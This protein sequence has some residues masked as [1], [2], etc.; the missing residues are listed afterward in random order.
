VGSGTAKGPI[1]FVNLDP[2]ITLTMG[3]LI[4]ARQDWNGDSSPPT[5][6]ST[7]VKV[8]K[9]PTAA[10]LGEIISRARPLEC[11][12]CLWLE[13]IV[14][15]ATVTVDIP[16]SPAIT[17]NADW[18][19]VHVDVASLSSAATI[20]ARQ[21]A[22]GVI[23]S[24][25][26]LP[27]PLRHVTGPTAWVSPPGVDTPLYLCQRAIT[28]HPLPG[29]EITVEHNDEVNQ[30]CFGATTGTFW[31]RRPLDI[32]DR[33]RVRQQF[34]HCE[35]RSGEGEYNPTEPVPPAPGFPYPVCAG[36]T[37]VEVTG[38]IPGA[39]VQFFRNGEPEPFCFAD[40]GEPPYR[41]N[42]PSL[43]NATRLGVRQTFC[44]F[45]PWSDITYVDIVP[46][47]P[48]DEPLIERP[49]VGCGAAVAVT[50]L[51]A[52]T[53]VRVVSDLWGGP[54]GEAT[55]DGEEFVDVPLHFPLIP[56]DKLQLETIQCGVF[57]ALTEIT[58]VLPGPE[59]LASPELD[60]PLDDCGGRITV[61]ALVPGA[62]LD[63]ERV[64][65][66]NAPDDAGLLLASVPVTRTQS[67]VA[68]PPL[69]P[70]SFIRVRQRLCGRTS[71]PS[72][73]VK[74]G[75]HPIHYLDN[76]THR[77]CQLS[78]S[79]PLN[80]P[81]MFDTT[82]VDV[83]GTDLGIPVEHGGH[84]YFFFGD[85]K[86][87]DDSEGDGDPIG[88]T[89][90]S[91]PEPNGVAL[92]WLLNEDGIFRRLIVEGVPKLANFEVPTGGFGYSGR[93]YLFIAREK[94][95]GKMQTS[96][97]AVTKQPSNDPN[98]NFQDLYKVASTL[99]G[100]VNAPAGPWLIHV[101]PTVVKNANWPGLPS[102]FGDGLLMFGTS[103]YQ[104]SNVY[105][106]WASITLGQH[107]PH[108]STW[109]FFKA[110][111]PSRWVAAPTIP[112]GQEPT[113][114]LNVPDPGPVAELSVAWQPR[115][116]RWIMTHTQPGPQVVIR[117]ARFPWG[118]WSAPEV[119]FDPNNPAR[120]AGNHLP[121]ERFVLFQH[122]A[123]NRLTVPYAPYIIPR[124]T[125]FDRSTRTLTVYYTM[126]VE[127]PPYNPQLMRSRLHCG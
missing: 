95:D 5:P 14:P 92:H 121:G 47:G 18:T 80:P 82:S 7:A 41:F 55:G 40:A 124:W 61:R 49:V 8:L 109:K 6:E 94:V 79:G 62:I 99:N 126:S 102:S 63:I 17:A 59:F 78:G 93:L 24:V 65:D 73:V 12:V 76:S 10:M 89:S 86:E 105:L 56:G 122:A 120:D 22:C 48:S 101:S 123:E 114:L 36:D 96:H 84:L 58:H 28:L 37:Q 110:D 112:A 50:G 108:P 100:G 31:L 20:H 115:M 103:L 11:G 64:P 32:R 117:T 1:T 72:V 87:T 30:F 46:A 42:L 26:T 21:V 53:K 67:S 19:A 70:G 77:L 83:V 71:R 9:T 33:I 118:P 81:R 15:G 69:D 3:R 4:T 90:A 27:N 2:G 127:D 74:T 60:E 85:C 54:I 57:S 29:S 39:H 23:G 51:T 13:G 75:D 44:D 98:Q 116:Q 66:P 43:G 52:G 104:A 25:V 111:H 97:L 125:R 38:L 106:A 16:G 45:G 107:P 91:S 35:L 119:I 68:V 34:H 113:K 88:W